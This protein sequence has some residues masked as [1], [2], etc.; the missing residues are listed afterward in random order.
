MTEAVGVAAGVATGVGAVVAGVGAGAAAGAG[1]E[2]VVAGGKSY[3]CSWRR[4]ASAVGTE[5]QDTS[6]V[7]V[8]ALTSW[9]REGA[10]GFSVY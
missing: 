9:T 3:F 10:G 2:A 4:Y 6:R 7:L 1:V 8:L 5:P